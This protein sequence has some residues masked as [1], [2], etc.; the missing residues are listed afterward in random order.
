MNAHAVAGN[1][2]GRNGTACI[3]RRPL[4]AGRTQPIGRLARPGTL[5]HREISRHHGG[6]IHL[7][8]E[9]Q[10]IPVLQGA[11]ASDFKLG[12]TCFGGELV[13]QIGGFDDALR[14]AARLSK[15][16]EY[17]TQNFPVYEKNFQ[18]YL[19][20]MGFPFMNS[21]ESFI[22]EELGEENYK[23]IEQI[24]RVQSKKGIQAS[25]PFEINIH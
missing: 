7:P 2:N 14:Y 24:R 12:G 19:G 3:N 4:S 11:D 15:I 5:V 13:D 10:F 8:V 21:R 25:L 1:G 17:K 6:R 18:D 22:K 23:V 9:D 16:K 20:Q